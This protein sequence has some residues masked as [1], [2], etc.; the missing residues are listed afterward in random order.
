M[1]STKKILI[2]IALLCFLICLSKCSKAKE[3]ADLVLKNGKIVTV[4]EAVPEVQAIAVKGDKILAVGSNKEIKRH[5]T[6]STKVIDLEGKL[7]VPGLIDSHGH[8]L[9]LGFAKMRIDLTK[10]E[11]WDQIVSLV[12]DAANRPGK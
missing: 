4:D 1:K 5:I 7:A 6:S 8:F 11:N 2:L 9:S 10:A 3:P 12:R